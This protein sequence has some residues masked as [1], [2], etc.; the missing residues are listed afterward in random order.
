MY[1]SG[2]IVDVAV[3]YCFAEECIFAAPLGIFCDAKFK[4]E[5]YILLK[6]M[7]KRDARGFSCCSN[8]ESN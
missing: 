2:E 4:R 5:S 1:R 8:T 3:Q 7:V 6:K